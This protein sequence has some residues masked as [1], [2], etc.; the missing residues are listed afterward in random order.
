MCG[1]PE[2]LPHLNQRTKNRLERHRANYAAITGAPFEHFFC[3]IL[4]NDVRAELI[5]GHVINETF[6][7]SSKA[8]VVQRGEVDRFYGGFFEGDFELLQYMQGAT[9]LDY[10][11]NKK[12]FGAIRPKIYYREQEIK[13]YLSD[14]KPPPAGFQFVQFEIDGQ[15]VELNVKATTDQMMAN[16]SHWEIETKKDLRIPAFVSLIKAAHLSM[17]SLF[18]YRYALSYAGRFIGEDILG[19]FYRVNREARTK[20]DAQRRAISFFKPFQHMIRPIKDGSATID[21]TLTDGIVHLCASA[22]GDPWGMIIFIKTGEL[23]HA[24][25]IPHQDNAE[26]LA[27]YLDFLKS[28]REKIHVM[29]GVYQPEAERWLFEP[30]R[31]AVNWPKDGLIYPAKIE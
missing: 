21:G 12:L 11:R 5:R 14:G 1:N 4:F 8:W 31:L 26:S 18:G 15:I 24:A 6:K 22:S 13:Y 10:F 16:T 30:D 3:P 20:G 25:L 17:F 7:G 28:D 19:K 23:R 2:E 9:L 29:R 27:I